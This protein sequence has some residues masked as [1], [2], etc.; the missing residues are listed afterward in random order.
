MRE[1]YADA[2]A[3]LAQARALTLP[4]REIDG[5]GAAHRRPVALRAPAT[6][7]ARAHAVRRARSHGRTTPRSRPK[8]RLARAHRA[9]PSARAEPQRA[10]TRRSTTARSAPTSVLARLEHDET[11]RAELGLAER[12]DH[13]A[14]RA[15]R[16]ALVGDQP[17][18]AA[19]RPLRIVRRDQLEPIAM[20]LEVVE[21]RRDQPAGAAALLQAR[22][23]LAVAQREHVLALDHDLAA[24]DH[25]AERLRRLDLRGRRRQAAAR[26]SARPRPRSTRTA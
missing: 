7:T 20:L 21:Q 2:A 24:R 13:L 10:P 16:R 19:E 14:E 22:V 25:D 18:L 6:S 11:Q 8:P 9:S 17:H 12:V 15:E 23:D 1:R 3:L 26:R 5:G 4:T